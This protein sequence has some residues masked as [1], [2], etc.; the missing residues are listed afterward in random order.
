MSNNRIVRKFLPCLA[1]AGSLVATIPSLV[2][3]DT[4][5]GFTIFSGVDAGSQ[6]TYRLDNGA[7]S[8]TDRYLLKIPGSKINSLGAAQIQ[9]TY[10]DYYKGKFDEQK[11][12]VMVDGKSIPLKSAKWER[13]QRAIV[14]NLAQ[15]LTTKDEIQVV[16]SN[17]QN[18]DGVG[19]YYFNCLVKSSVDFPIARNVGTWI[20]NIGSPQ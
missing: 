18:P 20:L 6:L 8:V 16:L 15:Q 10:P 2:S 1:L 13:E 9:I 14:I 4:L 12:E 3:A 19:T 11:I 7:R 17:V 5:P